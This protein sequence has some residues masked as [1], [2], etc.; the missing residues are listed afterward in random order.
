M[1]VRVAGLVTVS[2]SKTLDLTQEQWDDYVESWRGAFRQGGDNLLTA[3][4]AEVTD[5]LH[6]CEESSVVDGFEVE[7]EK[8]GKWEQV[9]PWEPDTPQP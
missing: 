1:K 3:T 9:F 8:D 7:I 2:V 4:L 5:D 6:D